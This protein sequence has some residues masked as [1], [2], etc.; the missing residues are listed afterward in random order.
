MALA[1]ARDTGIC[2]YHAELLRLRA[3]TDS[4][5]DARQA[6]IDAARELVRRQSAFSPNYVL[7]LTISTF[8]ANQRA[9]PSPTRLTA[10]P[11]TAHCPNSRGP[12]QFSLNSRHTP[13]TGRLAY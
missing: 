1:E 3:H 2:F 13:D 11:P 12:R 6:D 9:P 4:D 5:H 10:S 7:P 8:G